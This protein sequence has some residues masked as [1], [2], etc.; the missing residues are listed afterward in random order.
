MSNKK[1]S[2]LDDMKELS[3]TWCWT[4]DLSISYRLPIDYLYPIKYKSIRHYQKSMI[5]RRLTTS[6]LWF[7]DKIS[8]INRRAISLV[9]MSYG[10]YIY[11]LWEGLSMIDIWWWFIKAIGDLLIIHAWIIVDLSMIPS[12]S[13]VYS[14]IYWGATLRSIYLCLSLA[15]SYRW[16]IDELRQ[17]YRV[18]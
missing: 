5:Y 6:C 9:S 17:T 10:W 4:Y 3:V 7:I 12:W 14:M 16:S 13:D 2:S 18:L 15:K 1:R 11:E 8:M